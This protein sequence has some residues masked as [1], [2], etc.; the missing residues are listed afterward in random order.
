M[1]AP[2]PPP[3]PP[4]RRPRFLI[5]AIVAAWIVVLGALGFWAVRHDPPTV[6]EQRNIAQAVPVLQSATGRLLAAAQG[7]GR[8]VKLG[9]LQLT[10]GCRITPVRAGVEATRDVALYIP[11]DQATAALSAGGR[12]P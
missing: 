5:V 7:P 11:A 6:P 4:R 1:A 8:A 3:T 12:P 9:D 2:W 10:R